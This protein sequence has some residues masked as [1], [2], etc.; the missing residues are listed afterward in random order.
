[1]EPKGGLT[2]GQL[3]KLRISVQVAERRN[4]DFSLMNLSKKRI[5]HS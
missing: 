5:A 3:K 1:M 4:A 2:V